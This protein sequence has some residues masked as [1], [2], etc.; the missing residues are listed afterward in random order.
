MSRYNAL[1]AAAQ[2]FSAIVHRLAVMLASI[3]DS[4]ATASRKAELKLWDVEGRIHDAA[5]S[6]AHQ[7]ANKEHEAIQA[8]HD[9]VVGALA[10]ARRAMVRAESAVAASRMTIDGKVEAVYDKLAQ[11][12]ELHS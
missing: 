9:E 7:L 8:A 11:A 5:L 12:V 2:W 3:E 6:A 10:V 1:K 4:V